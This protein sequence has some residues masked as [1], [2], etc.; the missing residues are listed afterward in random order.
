MGQNPGPRHGRR[1]Q[2]VT[3]TGGVVELF[4]FRHGET[5]WNREGRC[6]GQ[7]DIPL[8]DTGRRQ[9]EALAAELAGSGIEAILCSDLTRAAATG[10]V[11]AAALGVP[12]AFDPG[13]REAHLGAAQGLLFREIAER[14]GP[15]LVDHWQG[16][17]SDADLSFPGG[18]S[19][20]EVTARAVAAIGRFCRQAPLSRIGISTHGGVM[21]RLASESAPGRPPVPIPN[22]GLVRLAFDPVAGRLTPGLAVPVG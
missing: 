12:I 11:V 17:A 3:G 9:A 15:D 20:A 6:Q 4:V 14:Y 2:A 5:D 10:R 19:G 18:E 8:S 16:A 7:L 13:L 1:G 21:R 22:A